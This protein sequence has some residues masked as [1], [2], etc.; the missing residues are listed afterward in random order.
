MKKTPINNTGEH[1][2]T[3]QSARLNNRDRAGRDGGRTGRGG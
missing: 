2:G 3:R 1:S